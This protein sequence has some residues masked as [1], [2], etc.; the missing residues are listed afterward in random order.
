M[1]LS[2]K[3]DARILTLVLTLIG[4]ITWYFSQDG[5]IEGARKEIDN[6]ILG[7]ESSYN[8]VKEEYLDGPVQVVSNITEEVKNPK[9]IIEVEAKEI[10]IKP[11]LKS[12]IK[13]E[14]KSE[15]KTEKLNELTSQ[16]IENCKVITEEYNKISSKK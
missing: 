15:V 12:E 14:L 16:M 8:K 13:T 4:A 1:N 6:T 3:G 5:K 11:E 9:N 7:M 10:E 2:N